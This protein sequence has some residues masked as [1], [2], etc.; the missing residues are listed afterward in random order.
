MLVQPILYNIAAFDASHTQ[1]FKFFV[2]GGDRVAS[3]KLIIRKNDSSQEVVYERIA[4]TF[5]L[6]NLYDP[7]DATYPN[8]LENGQYYQAVIITYNEAGGSGDSSVESLPI[9]FY[10]YTQ[11]TFDFINLPTGNIVQGSNYTFSVQ[12]SQTENEP[13]SQYNF[14]LYDTSNNLV[15]TSGAVYTGSTTVP[16]EISYTFDGF[17]NGERYKLLVAGQTAEGT[18][19]ST[20]VI[21]IDIAYNTPEIFSPMYVT[22]NCDGGY[23]SVQ[24]NL[25]LL[26][27]SYEGGQPTYIDG[28][29]IDLS[30]SDDS[31]TWGQNYTIPDDFSVVVW[32]YNF[33][34]DEDIIILK[35]E[36]GDIVRVQYKE[37][38]GECWFELFVYYVEDSETHLCYEIMSNVLML[39]ESSYNIQMAFRC[40]DGLYDVWCNITE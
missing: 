5:S 1:T 14:S 2:N 30:N 34:N 11:P 12:Y 13:L 24:S 21:F 32:G 17:L 20:P 33:I 18:L 16:I 19:I 10:C 39:P 28:S 31:V 9:Q 29:A 26:D 25:I 38:S 40:I 7:S 22:N 37:E 4:T 27:G 3:N 15:A 23:I 36:N 6:E 35:D 8:A